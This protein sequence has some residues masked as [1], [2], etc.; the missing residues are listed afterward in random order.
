MNWLKPIRTE[1]LPHNHIFQ[2]EHEDCPA[3][4]TID[5]WHQTPEYVKGLRYTVG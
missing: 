2:D 4:A 5:N 1:R 3:C